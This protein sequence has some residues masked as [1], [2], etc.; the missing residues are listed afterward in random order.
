MPKTFS[1]SERA[2]IRDKLIEEAGRCLALYGIRKT[3]V[4]EIVRRVNIPKGTFYLFYESKERLLFDVVMKLNDDIQAEMLKR[5]SGLSGSPDAETL[6]NLIFGLYK[7]LDASFLPKLIADGE[8]DLLMRKLPDDMAKL[9]TEKDDLSVEKLAAMVPG[10]NAEDIKVF[11]AALRG[12]FLSL[13]YKR[14]VGEEVFDE[15]LR[16][17]IRGVV[18]Q[19][20]EGEKNDK[21]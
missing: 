12:I 19:M 21:R 11:S 16:V 17:M 14:E 10:I 8:L 9:H 6:T 2:F 7:S 3:T 20:F 1:D 15:A 13:L 4:D 5:V 18:I